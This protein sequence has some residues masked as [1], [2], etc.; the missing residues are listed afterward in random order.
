[1]FLRTRFSEHA[2]QYKLE[3]GNLRISLSELDGLIL[4]IC[5]TN[6]ERRG[7]GES[8]IVKVHT[9]YEIQL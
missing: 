2:I 9:Q 4:Q 3:G 8:F 6:K 5:S 7:G 1:M